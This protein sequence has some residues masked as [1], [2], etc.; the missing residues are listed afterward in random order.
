M[1]L[2]G[3]QRDIEWMR[4]LPSDIPYA[5]AQRSTGR[6]IGRTAFQ[7]VSPHRGEGWFGGPHD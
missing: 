7:K 1:T 3:F 6:V 2:A 4:A 5:I